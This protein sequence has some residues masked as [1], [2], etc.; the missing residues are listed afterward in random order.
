MQED[1]V[2]QFNYVY[3]CE[4]DANVQIKIGSLEGRFEKPHSDALLADPSLAQC[5]TLLHG[6]QSV[7][8]K[9]LFV[10]CSVCHHWFLFACKS[11][12]N[13]IF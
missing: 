5:V 13:H 2:N 12:N 4:L 11:Q 7:P 8:T 1:G 10:T 3:S 6:S 9:D